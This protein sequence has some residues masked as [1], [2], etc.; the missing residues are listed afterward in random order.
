MVARMVDLKASCSV[1]LRDDLTVAVSA[2][3]QVATKADLWD[4]HW[5]ELTDV[6]SVAM[7]GAK[8]D[9]H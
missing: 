4:D 3:R 9:V 1:V 8:M 5:A 2:H 7:K 6:H